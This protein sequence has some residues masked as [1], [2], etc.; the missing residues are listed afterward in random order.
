MNP[1]K[2]YS[3]SFRRTTPIVWKRSNIYNFHNLNACAMHSADSGLTSVSGT[4]NKSLYF[5]QAKIIGHFGTIL[6]C[7]LSCVRSILLGTSETHLAGRGPRN[8]LSFIV[9]QGNYDIIERR[10]NVQLSRCTDFYNFL[11]G[12][13]CLFCHISNSNII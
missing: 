7:H 3:T 10:M 1:N 11:L 9:C 13:D 5:S 6:C 8:D 4:L 2:L 12:C